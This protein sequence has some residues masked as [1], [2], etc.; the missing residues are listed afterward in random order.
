MRLWSAK[1]GFSFI[2]ILVVVAVV[3]L[4]A[5]VAFTSLSSLHERNLLRDASN[6]LV[7]HLEES[8]AR[9]VAG[10]GGEPHGLYFAEDYY[11]QFIGS[12]YDALEPSNVVHQLDPAITLTI[13]ILEGEDE[14]IFSRI[15]GR[16]SSEAS[17]TI[18][19]QNNP[20]EERVVLVGAGGDISYEE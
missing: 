4:L 19:L 7:F 3:L 11:V 20:D 9:S 15:T 5:L 8:K 18:E 12:E 10:T 14:I 17:F 1:N 16:S 13:D 2:E 6:T